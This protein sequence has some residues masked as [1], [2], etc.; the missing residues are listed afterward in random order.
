MN[1]AY[2]TFI[3]VGAGAG[4]P[5]PSRAERRARER[6]VAQ[7]MARLP[8]RL[9]LVPRHEWPQHCQD[10]PN[11]PDRVW[12]SRDYLVQQ[13]PAAAPALCRLSINSTLVRDGDWADG[14]RWDELQRIKAEVGFDGMWAV[15]VYPEAKSLVN[16]ANMRHLWVLERPPLFAWKDDAT[17]DGQ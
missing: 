3:G 2:K 9:T 14:L 6:E 8:R 15:E 5:L 11:A 4:V 16:V 1:D 12:R 10:N 7:A 17:G 13:Y